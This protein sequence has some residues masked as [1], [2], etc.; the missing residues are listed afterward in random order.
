MFDLI[1]EEVLNEISPEQAYDNF[2]NSIPREDF[3]K[4]VEANGKFDALVK[5]LLG[6]Y[7]KKNTTLE[8]CLELV[9]L[10]KTIDN[11]AR[12]TVSDKLKKKDYES[13]D[14][15][16]Y[17]LTH[18][19][20][21]TRFSKSSLIKNGYE[22]IA[23]IET[24]ILTATF[25]YEA[26]RKHFGY[27]EWCTASDRLGR[28]DGYEQF[29]YYTVDTNGALI[30]I[31][32]E[33]NKN[34]TYQIQIKNSGR[35]G[36]ICD[37][38]DNPMSYI[39]LLR[40]LT[41]NVYKK[42]ETIIKENYPHWIKQT[43]ELA[44]T[45][46]E[47]QLSRQKYLDAKMKRFEAKKRRVTEEA[48]QLNIQISKETE[49]K[50]NELK[51]S[52]LYEN[53]D[54]L[55]SLRVFGE[56]YSE[57]NVE[58]ITEYFNTHH[59]AVIFNIEYLPNYLVLVTII[60]KVPFYYRCSD[61]ATLE[62]VPVS[63]YNSWCDFSGED[64]GYITKGFSI[65]A[66]EGDD[67]KLF[68][69]FVR[70]AF[71]INCKGGFYFCE[72]LSHKLNNR[73]F[74]FSVNNNNGMMYLPS[75]GKTYNLVKEPYHYS[76]IKSGENIMLCSSSQ[77]FVFSKLMKELLDYGGSYDSCIV[78]NKMCIISHGKENTSVLYIDND[79]LY[80]GKLVLN[81]K[82]IDLSNNYTLLSNGV[83]VVATTNEGRNFGIVIDTE[84]N[85]IYT[86]F[87]AKEETKRSTIFCHGSHSICKTTGKL[88]I[89][90]DVIKHK[91]FLP[92]NGEVKECD[93]YG[94]LIE[95]PQA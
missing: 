85:V 44:K 20:E 53:L 46:E 32:N 73:A 93:M 18:T 17:D 25:T 38:K 52:K 56:L 7:M 91:Y 34:A 6:E 86:I 67:E 77:F 13:I 71:E 54:F 48:K 59:N 61:S 64:I 95:N 4:I 80:G 55:N 92:I 58:E 24:W 45:E 84:R 62:K 49:K 89:I 42:L 31:T 15:L 22:E 16:I 1:V 72:S 88:L 94:N 23:R 8:E 3:D 37:V 69:S 57:N 39:D 78:G 28:Y 10:Y 12:I 5:F 50:Y 63:D 70:S 90:F 47:F 79:I 87:D 75:N 9:K 66:E 51:E 43:K 19:E 29:L 40:I 83:F 2:Y 33:K 65:I 14:E 60:V 35:F 76:V 41:E 21:I 81:D 36:Q 11:K 30:Q 74:F 26:N 82:I 27:T 68:K